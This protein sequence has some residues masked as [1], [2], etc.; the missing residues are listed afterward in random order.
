MGRKKL[1][2]TTLLSYILHPFFFVRQWQNGFLEFFFCYIHHL[3]S[4]S[5]LVPGHQHWSHGF[6]LPPPCCWLSIQVYPE[7]HQ[8]SGFVVVAPP[9]G[10]HRKL[11][12]LPTSF[13]L[14]RIVFQ[15]A[16]GSSDCTI[17]AMPSQMHSL[18]HH[19]P[20]V[21]SLFPFWSKICLLN[22]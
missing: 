7:D 19:T 12:L 16:F 18:S 15:D 17:H 3:F 10:S 1:C 20:I 21:L 22:S 4:L 9:S 8:R 2:G 13:V 5:V 14:G 6:R 11:L